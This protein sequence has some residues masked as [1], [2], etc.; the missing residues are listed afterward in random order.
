[1]LD[2]LS[3]AGSADVRTHLDLEILATQRNRQRV[4][5]DAGRHRH[6]NATRRKPAHEHIGYGTRDGVITNID[7]GSVG[8]GTRVLIVEDHE[9]LAQSLRFAL[10]ADGFDVQETH[11][12]R[13]ED[14][15]RAAED[16]DPDLVLLDLDIGGDLGSS[17]PLIAPL[18]ERGTQVVMLTGITDRVRLAECVEAGAIGIVSK[19]EPFDHL[20]AAVKTAAEDRTLLAP[21]ERDELLAELRR[22]RRADEER[23]AVFAR[24]TPRE[25]DVLAALMDGM[26]AE[27]IAKDAVVSLATVRSQIRSILMKLG[28]HSQLEA[29]ALARRSGWQPT[30]E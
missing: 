10:Q 15:L 28:V 20:I 13:G 3:V 23:L 5:E 21:A 24:L 22:Q 2:T 4:T 18:R 1:V 17:L 11:T 16:L 7:E 29:V 14:I 19:A 12:Q 26:S 25:R 6:H 27:Q 8:V 30:A 9:L